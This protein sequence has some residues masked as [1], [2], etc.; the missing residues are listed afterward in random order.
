MDGDSFFGSV[1]DIGFSFCL[2]YFLFFFGLFS[3]KEIIS[4]LVKLIILVV[5]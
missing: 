2:F 5:Q 1:N 4:P 3:S